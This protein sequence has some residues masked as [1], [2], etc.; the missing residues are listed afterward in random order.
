MSLT[1][2][3]IGQLHVLM[4][5]LVGVGVG[6]GGEV[7]NIRPLLDLHTDGPAHIRRTLHVVQVRV[8]PL[9][10][11]VVGRVRCK[12]IVDIDN[13]CTFLQ[14]LASLLAGRTNNGRVPEAIKETAS[15]RNR[16]IGRGSPVM[17]KMLSVNTFIVMKEVPYHSTVP[18]SLLPW[19]NATVVPLV[20]WVDVA[21]ASV[22][23]CS[24][25]RTSLREAIHRINNILGD[26][27]IL[28]SRNTTTAS[29]VSINLTSILAYMSLQEKNKKI[30]TDKL[31]IKIRTLLGSL[32]G[33]W[34][35]A[36]AVFSML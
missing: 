4:H 22:V 25:L 2:S 19:C 20:L 32:R 12:V 21:A 7:D 1:T 18:R 34:S 29:G 11:T 30:R 36:R 26:S 28:T 31:T 3:S 15:G 24:A 33:L 10:M 14:R 16:A 13:S 8:A 17:L 5:N 6:V 27:I 9:A 35:M 23:G